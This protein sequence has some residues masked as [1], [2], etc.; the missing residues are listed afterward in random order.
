M[1]KTADPCQDFFQ[2]ACGGWIE[3]HPIPESKSRWTQFDILRDQ[4]TETLKGK[5]FPFLKNTFHKKF[6]K[7]K[8]YDSLPRSKL[9]NNNIIENRISD[10][11][12]E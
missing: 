6:A 10:P 11:T 5:K 12:R 4:L 9:I 7:R 3:K 1:D 2:Y 8:I